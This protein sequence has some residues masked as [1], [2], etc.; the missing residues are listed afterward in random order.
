[1]THFLFHYLPEDFKS[2]DEILL[3]GEGCN[4]LGVTVTKT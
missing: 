4:T 3:W 1:M 2:R